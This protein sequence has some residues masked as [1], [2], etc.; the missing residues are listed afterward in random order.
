M[1]DV[2]KVM[3]ATATFGPAAAERKS[4]QVSFNLQLLIKYLVAIVIQ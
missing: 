1:D 2:K 3:G 4:A